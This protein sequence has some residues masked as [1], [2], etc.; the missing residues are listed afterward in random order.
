M[1]PNHRT[2]RNLISDRCILLL[3]LVVYCNRVYNLL[4]FKSFKSSNATRVTFSYSAFSNVLF[5]GDGGGPG[6]S[7]LDLGS[8]VLAQV[9]TNVYK[10][11]Y[12]L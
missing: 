8:G 5:L 1:Q 3:K 10:N 7:P 12:V 6:G 9:G 2:Q 11:S 4:S